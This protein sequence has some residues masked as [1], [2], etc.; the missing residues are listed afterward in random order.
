M[1]GQEGAV[2]LHLLPNN[3]KNRWG[4]HMNFRTLVISAAWAALAL[5]ACAAQSDDEAGKTSKPALTQ[6]A[7]YEAIGV[8]AGTYVMD[9]H[10][11]YVT[12]SYTHMG[13]S[14][15][16]LA[17]RDVDAR[18]DFDPD[19][20]ENSAVEVTIQ[21]DSI[22]SGVDIFDGHLNSENFF[23][24]EEHPTI[25]FKSTSFVRSGQNGGTMTG[26]LT[27]MGIT[28]TVSLDVK[29]LA[30]M[31][32]PL[33]KKPTLGLE[34]SG[35]LNRSDFGLGKYVPNVSDEVRIQIS[36]EFNKND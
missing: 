16:Q 33:N 19:H 10:H 21:A 30:A 34:A 17:F 31:T 26:D 18:I 2:L 13:F 12:F 27:L 25:S 6:T 14:N 8:P 32:H 20:P 23:N 5:P 22:D 35:T 24:T 9:N 3:Q 7:T 36:G 1:A 15:P 4:R 29:L 28:K 11:G